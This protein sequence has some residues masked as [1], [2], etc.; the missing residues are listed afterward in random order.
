MKDIFGAIALITYY[1]VACALLPTLMRGLL[2]VKMELVRKTQHVAYSLSIFLLLK[3]FSTWY[4]AVLSACLLIVLAY[5]GLRL[6]EKWGRYKTLFADRNKKG[7]ELRKQLLLVQFTFALLIWFFWGVLGVEFTYL[8]VVAVMGW[9]FGDAAA[10]LVGK[11]FGRRKFRLP[12]ISTKTMEGTS[13]MM[14]VAG[15]TIFWT[16]L[17]YAGKPWYLSLLVACCVAPISG[18]VELFSKKGSDTFTVPMTIAFTAWPIIMLCSLF[19]W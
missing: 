11:Y 9:G 1:L 10:A 7:G 14:V 13:A 6:L 5:P 8:V 4:W 16:L 12:F 17:L 19:G 2:G 15:T 3:L 18:V